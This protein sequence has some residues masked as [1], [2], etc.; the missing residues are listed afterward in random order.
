MAK[1]TRRQ[2]R[3]LRK[4]VTLRYFRGGPIACA[5]YGKL[6]RRGYIRLEPVKVQVDG[7][8]IGR[9]AWTDY[10]YMPTAKGRKALGV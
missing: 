5:I 9:F 10:R 6:I 7:Y 4:I 2:K 1:L 3:E 8:N